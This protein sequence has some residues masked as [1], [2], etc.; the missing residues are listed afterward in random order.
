M[1]DLNV[2]M[3]IGRLGRDPELRRWP[4]GRPVTRFSLAT[5]QRWKNESGGLDTRTDWHRIVAF[6]KVAERAQEFLRKG[7]QVFVEGRLQTRS[8]QDKNGSKA[9]S[10]EVVLRQMVLLGKKDIITN[11]ADP[12]EDSMDIE[13]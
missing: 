3:L 11:P 4:S 5:G 9:F 7:K 13:S 8:Y 1:S 12:V 10:T 6:G 2:V